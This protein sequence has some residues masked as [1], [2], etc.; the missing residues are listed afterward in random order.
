M[1]WQILTNIS[2][3]NQ[4]STKKSS[5]ISFYQ[6]FKK[7]MLIWQIWTDISDTNQIS[8]GNVLKLIF[9]EN[10]MKISWFDKYELT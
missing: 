7:L 6:N 8:T 3:T 10:F 9:L 4:I 1:N 5:I 2:G